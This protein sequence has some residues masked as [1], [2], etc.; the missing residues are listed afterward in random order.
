LFN[1]N[2]PQLK[3]IIIK[4]TRSTILSI[5]V[6]S[7]KHMLQ[8]LRLNSLITVKYCDELLWNV[9]TDHYVRK[10]RLLKIWNSKIN[11]NKRCEDILLANFIFLDVFRGDPQRCDMFSERCTNAVASPFGVTEALHVFSFCYG[12][13]K[14]T[15]YIEFSITLFFVMKYH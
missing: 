2:K 4:A 15:S 14:R 11:L 7:L 3:H 8:V 9:N 10:I 12:C 5:H 13:R 6:C 1:K